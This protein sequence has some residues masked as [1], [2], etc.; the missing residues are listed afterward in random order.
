MWLASCKRT[1]RSALATYLA[2]T[3]LLTRLSFPL[4]FLLSLLLFCH[5]F[6]PSSY[7]FRK[8]RR[9]EEL[10]LHS[11]LFLPTYFFLIVG[12]NPPSEL[13]LSL[14]YLGKDCRFL[15][16]EQW[17]AIDE[18]TESVSFGDLLK[19]K[20]LGTHP[21]PAESFLILRLSRDKS[22]SIRV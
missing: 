21:R 20:A 16:L 7:S 1:A 13:G 9:G 17:K 3:A 18:N 8:G 22:I 10:L 4:I 6:L 12:S 2:L 11:E 15:F 14:G 19:M 5:F